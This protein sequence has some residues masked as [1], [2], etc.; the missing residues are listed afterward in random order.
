MT[1]TKLVSFTLNEFEKWRGGFGYKLTTAC[2][3][4]ASERLC[5]PRHAMSTTHKIT[6]LLFEIKRSTFHCFCA[7]LKDAD[8]LVNQSG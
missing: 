7:L 3:K 5:N 1:S 8:S 6:W 4:S 2:R